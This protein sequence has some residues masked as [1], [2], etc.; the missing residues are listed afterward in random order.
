[1]ASMVICG[2]H[3]VFQESFW[4]EIEKGEEKEEARLTTVS[5]YQLV[6]DSQLWEV[7]IRPPDK[8]GLL[9]LSVSHS[10]GLKFYF[11]GLLTLLC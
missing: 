5:L 8:T 6:H 1:M 4:N 7:D 2:I 10:T 9:H 3:K 11:V